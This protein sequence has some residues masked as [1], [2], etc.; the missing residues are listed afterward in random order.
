MVAYVSTSSEHL[1]RMRG[2]NNRF[3][4]LETIS[5]KLSNEEHKGVCM[6]C[7]W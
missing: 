4:E 2:L 1:E 5:Q 7:G 6:V 3:N